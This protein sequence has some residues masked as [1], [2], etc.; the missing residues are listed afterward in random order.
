MKQILKIFSLAI[1]LL[2][3]TGAAHSEEIVVIV[4][5]ANTTAEITDGELKNFF[6][7]RKREWSD[8]TA[9]RFIDRKEGVASRREFLSG[10]IGK[11]ARDIELYWIG[12]KLYS[13]DAAPM[14]VDSDASVVSLVSAL[15]GAVGYVS[16]ESPLNPSVKE[17]EVIR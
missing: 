10:Y 9:V 13:G 12:Q 7:K 2:L 1:A 4:N 17:L 3:S 6:L 14:Q 11:S 15:R 16:A 5:A 8:G